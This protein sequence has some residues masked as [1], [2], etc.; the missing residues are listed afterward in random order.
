MKEHYGDIPRCGTCNHD[1]S[2]CCCPGSAYEKKMTEQI[3][4]RLLERIAIA[5]EKIAGAKYTHMTTELVDPKAP[6]NP[7][8]GR[9]RAAKTA[10]PNDVQLLIK[11]YIDCFRQRYGPNARPDVGGKVQGLM[12][13]MLKDHPLP[14]LIALVQAFTQMDDDWF[15]KKC[16]D[17][18]TL[19]GNIGKV[20]TALLNGTARAE[21]RSY[22]ATVLKKAYGENQ[23][24]IPGADRSL[25]G[26]VRREGLPGG[27]SRALSPGAG[28]DS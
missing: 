14:R 24:D 1:L 11:A 3:T 17:F 21:D 6:A 23:S 4:Q 8:A 16:H 7:R 15:K 13:T 28:Q 19:H 5:L 22:W 25:T 27:A 10:A 26:D 2:R 9:H 20:Q 18:P 12:R